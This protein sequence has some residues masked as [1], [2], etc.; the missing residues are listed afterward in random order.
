M[1]ACH[2]GALRMQRRGAV[3]ATAHDLQS[4]SLKL[5]SALTSSCSASVPNR[6]EH[7][8]RR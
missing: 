1:I 4:Q 6:A 7:R 8:L 3:K 2:H 5:S